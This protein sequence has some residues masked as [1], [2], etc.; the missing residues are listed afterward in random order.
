MKKL[1]AIIELLRPAHWVKNLLVFAA[2]LFSRRYTELEC[3]PGAILA[4][5]ELARLAR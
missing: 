1:T 5:V 3:W 4:F 2:I